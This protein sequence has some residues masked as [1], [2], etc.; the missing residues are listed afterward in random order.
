MVETEAKNDGE[1]SRAL[2]EKE[3]ESE[4]EWESASLV[5]DGSIHNNDLYP[6]ILLFIQTP[7]YWSATTLDYSNL[8]LFYIF[9]QGLICISYFTKFPTS[10]L[11]MCHSKMSS[12][13]CNMTEVTW[14]S[15][16]A[17]MAHNIVSTQH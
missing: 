10:F 16:Y 15:I 13:E 7:S 8:P 4:K 11:I 17:D 5:R 2:E 9:Y 12:W 14:S 1:S 3:F 6:C